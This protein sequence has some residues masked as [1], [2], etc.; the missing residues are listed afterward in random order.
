MRM[1][2]K[3]VIRRRWAM[4]LAALLLL[5]L[6]W[7][8]MDITTPQQCKVPVEQMSYFCKELLYS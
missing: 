6:F 3:F 1:E 8:L 7:W 4:A 5:A 2:R